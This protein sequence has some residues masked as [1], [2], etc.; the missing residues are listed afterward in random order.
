MWV[1]FE[2]FWADELRE[3]EGKLEGCGRKEKQGWASYK[4]GHFVSHGG[5]NGRDEKPAQEQTFEWEDNK[6]GKM[7]KLYKIL[8]PDPALPRPHSPPTPPDFYVYIPLL[9]D[10]TFYKC[11]FIH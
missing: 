5:E 1:T 11:L 10:G 7:Q 9:L 4:E 6:N 3:S 2:S 8:N